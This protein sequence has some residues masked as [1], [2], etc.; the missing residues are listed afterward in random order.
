MA[1]ALTFFSRIPSPFKLDFS[2]EN[3]SKASRYFTLVGWGLGFIV[4]FVF[5]IS[6]QIFS[7]QISIWICI[8][9]NLLL[10][11][12]FHQDG[13]ADMAD[14]C[15]GGFTI[16]KKLEI[17]KDS[18]LGTYGACILFFALSGQF[19]LLNEL[20]QLDP[21]AFIWYLPAAYAISRAVASSFIFDMAYQTLDRVSKSKP[22][23]NQQ[24]RTDLLVSLL[25]AL[26]VCFFLGWIQSLVLILTL[27]IFR[28]VFKGF[29]NRQL[30]G[31]T[32]DCLGAAQQISELIIYL[33]LIACIGFQI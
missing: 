22:L 2:A 10:T 18:R 7:V 27:M 21:N 6:N 32:G 4:A 11:G 17:M 12:C 14:G 28:V 13:L 9:C 19:L 24:S 26:P 5:W 8:A 31:Y 29:L 23:A 16:E 30:K 15:G 33:I 3:L 20:S 25:T 1:L